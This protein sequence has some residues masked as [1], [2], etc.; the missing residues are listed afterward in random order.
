MAD[1][2]GSK[3]AK[4]LIFLM[5]SAS[6]QRRVHRNE[7]RFVAKGGAECRST[8]ARRSWVR[9]DAKACI[10]GLDKISRSRAWD[11]EPVAE[12]GAGDRRGTLVR[13]RNRL[14]GGWSWL[15]PAG[16]SKVN[17]L[18]ASRQT[19]VGGPQTA[20]RPTAW[21]LST[22]R[23]SGPIPAQPCA[24]L[25]GI[26]PSDRPS[27]KMYSRRRMDAVPKPSARSFQSTHALKIAQTMKRPGTRLLAVPLARI[28][29]A[30]AR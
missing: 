10:N 19:K 6:L 28:K 20:D 9:I 22:A 11:S 2:R 7:F 27:F 14:G 17:S 16:P 8:P 15:D 3:S 4:R 1:L 23:D 25:R 12:P 13:H 21:P 26:S 29:C 5:E 24:Y 18:G 30:L